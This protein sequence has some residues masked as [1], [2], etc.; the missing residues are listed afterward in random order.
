MN[1]KR[2]CFERVQ[3]WEERIVEVQDSEFKAQSLNSFGLKMLVGLNSV[4]SF[5]KGFLSSARLAGERVRMVYGLSGGRIADFGKPNAWAPFRQ[6]KAFKAFGFKFP[7]NRKHFRCP[8]NR[9][10]FSD[11]LFRTLFPGLHAPP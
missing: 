11:A 1:F 5:V 8:L 6:T 3:S 7:Q 10:C 9:A 2:E 4:E